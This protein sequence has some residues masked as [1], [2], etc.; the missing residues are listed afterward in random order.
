M[1][2]N[3]KNKNPHRQRRLLGQIA[4]FA[5]F[6]PKRRRRRALRSPAEC[7]DF[8]RLQGFSKPFGMSLNACLK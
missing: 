5:G 4:H 6:L 2:N 3:N 7:P 1:I 8:S